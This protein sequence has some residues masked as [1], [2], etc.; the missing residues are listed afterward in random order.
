MK[1]LKLMLGL[2]VVSV[3]LLGCDKKN[4]DNTIVQT[5][6]CGVGQ[7]YSNGGCYNQ[8]GYTGPA[9]TNFTTGFY[10]DNY[11][12]TSQIRVVN[13]AKMKEL[14]KYGMGVCDR[15]ANNYGQAN[16]DSY[17][18]GSMDIIIQFPMTGSAVSSNS[19]LAT[20]IAQPRYN[21]YFNYQAQLP[22]GWGVLG[23][24]IGWATGIYLPDP[25]YY[26][27]AT[28]NPL[29]LQMVVSA[30]NNSAGFEAR[31]YG[32]YWTG[33][34]TTVLAIQVPQG[35]VESS[36]FNFNLQVQGTTAAQGTMSRCRT[37]NC[38]L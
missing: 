2:A 6:T 29:Q 33:L 3:M 19:L 17:I 18:S 9:L 36:S 16:C 11:S 14:F 21:S 38:G 32:D 13:S 26:T 31:G 30:I 20:F 37:I 23:A 27:G 25:Q 7:Y 35:K 12:G 4:D 1:N 28:R 8:G 5:P 34:N 24:A 22:S 10:A 15:A